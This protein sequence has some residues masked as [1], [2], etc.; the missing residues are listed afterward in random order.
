[1]TPHPINVAFQK[2]FQPTNLPIIPTKQHCVKVK[3]LLNLD[4]QN[5]QSS[6]V[7]LKGKEE[8][9]RDATDVELEFRQ[10]S[11]FFYLTGVE[12][13][14][15]QVLFDLKTEKVYLVVPT[16]P[17]Y[18]IFWKGPSFDSNELLEL[19]DVDEVIQEA[20]I[21]AL[22]NTLKPTTIYTLEDS[23]PMHAFQQMMPDC[24]VNQHSLQPALDEA[25]LIK[26]PWEIDI[27]RQVSH[28][29]SQAH[30]A[31][32]EQYRQEMTEADLAALFR[33][34]CAQNKVY[35]Q[36]YLPIVASGSRTATLH[37]S[38]NNQRI[39]KDI[40]TLILVDAGG[41]K[42]CYG[43]DITRTFPAHGRFSEEAKTIYNIVLKMQ[44]VVLSK[45]M[46]GVY[47]NDLHKLSVEVLCKELTRIG[48]LTYGSQEELIQVGI[49]NAFYYHSLGHS[50]GLDVH[51]VGGREK[52]QKSFDDSATESEFLISRP[53]EEHMILTVEPG[54]YFNRTM[55][56]IWTQYPGY[57]K[58]FDMEM[59]KKY[60]GVG[61]VRIE[62][63]IVV[64]RHGYENLTTVPK[65]VHEIEAL[66]NV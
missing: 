62:D 54:L 52:K 12:E 33:W 40:H 22:L 3:R 27:I 57:Q 53:L 64:T 50:V 13:P 6:I 65:Q 15:F 45:L 5:E 36:A 21:A 4:K 29:S 14:G 39:P 18:D 23:L 63:T 8:S 55:L 31:L 59:L 25:R 7:Y 34:L 24:S 38:K 47:W 56:D 9:T 20:D 10:E 49:P 41:E 43:S 44:E 11:Y 48:I 30:I 16:V 60:E 2:H 35:R 46:P 42:H 51:D 19:Y 17:E 32:M 66:M 61:G 58:Y 26:F 28:S 37:Y 1:M